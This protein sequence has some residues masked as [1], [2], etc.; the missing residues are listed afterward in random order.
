MQVKSEIHKWEVHSFQFDCRT[1]FGGA[2]SPETMK[3]FLHRVSALPEDSIYI[4]S[5][6]GNTHL[7]LETMAVMEGGHVRGGTEDE[8]FLTPGV[9]G[10]NPDHVNRIANIAKLLGREIASVDEAKAMIGL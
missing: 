1:H 9:F 7:N 4:T 10:D 6:T 2:W 8:P 3:E 5:V